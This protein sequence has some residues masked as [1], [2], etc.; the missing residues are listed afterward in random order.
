MSKMFGGGLQVMGFVT[1]VLG[2]FALV[3]AIRLPGGDAFAAAIQR[4]VWIYSG[5]GLIGGGISLVATG[6]VITLLAD[7]RALLR[8]PEPDLRRHNRI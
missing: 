7:I 1:V 4:S 6:T 5:L 8:G 2:A 3:Y